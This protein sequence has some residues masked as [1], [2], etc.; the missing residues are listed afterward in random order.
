MNESHVLDPRSLAR[1]A[2]AAS[3]FTAVI[4]AV[5]A[6]GLAAQ[7]RRWLGF[8]FSGV[9]PRIGEAGS[10]LLDNARFVLGMT[11]A[12]WLAQLRFKGSRAAPRGAGAGLVLAGI[13]LAVDV[14]V[15]LAALVNTALVG[16]AVGAY[17]WRMLAALLPHGPFEICAYCI[18]ANLLL[19]AHRRPIARR[20]WTV[21]VVATLGLLALAALLE[22]FIWLG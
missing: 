18:A 16:L 12:G 10:I 9:P 11:A 4:A 7:T 1:I 21:A 13:G 14:F 19:T 17:G 8:G 15:L 3:A 20:E 2:G 5:V 22:T 6:I